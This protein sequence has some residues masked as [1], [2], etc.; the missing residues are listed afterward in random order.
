VP[1][2]DEKMIT[3]NHDPDFR[4]YW[5]DKKSR[6]ANIYTVVKFSGNEIYFLKHDI[7]KIIINK[8]EFGT[9]NCYQNLNGASIKQNCIKLNID[10]LGNIS[11]DSAH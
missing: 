6:S 5:S 4:K 8:V 9:Q 3:D 10:R 11:P 1:V 7:A 2:K